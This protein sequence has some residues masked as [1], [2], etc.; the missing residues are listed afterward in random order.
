MHILRA[1]TRNFPYIFLPSHPRLDPVSLL[2][3]ALTSSLYLS[4]SSLAL[5]Y[6]VWIPFSK[7]AG[8]NRSLMDFKKCSVCIAIQLKNPPETRN[9]K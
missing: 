7:R 2:F 4:F 8:L 6:F 1:K 5:L 3:L 9:M